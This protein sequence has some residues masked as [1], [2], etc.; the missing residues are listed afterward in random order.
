MAAAS[1]G[2]AHIAELC[3]YIAHALDQGLDADVTAKTQDHILD[4]FAAMVS[5]AR[6]GPGKMAIK[7]ARTLGGARE[8]GVVGTR[9]T[10]TAINAAMAN[11]MM[12]HA[13]E[14]DDSHLASRSHLGCSIVPGALAMAEKC[15]RGGT[16]LLRAVALGY[17]VGARF[18]LALNLGG[19]DDYSLCSHSHG[20][21]FGVA[22]AAAALAGADAGDVQNVL[23]F[24]AQQA[25]G[26]KI[27]MRDQDHLEK[28]FDFGG[29]PARN[30]VTA[31]C[32]VATGFT[33]VPDAICGK[34]GYLANFS[35]D[36]SP[37]RL[38]EGL[39]SRF[40]I[41]DTNIKKWS[42][43][44]PIQAAL[45]SL[46]VLIAEHAITA[47]QVE[48]IAAHMPD[49]RAFIV[50]DRDM[51][52]INLQHLLA[53]MVL[54]GGLSFATSHDEDRMADKAVLEVKRR[55]TLVPEAFLTRA[56]PERQAIIKVTL[57]DGRTLEHRTYDV[58]GTPGNPMGGAEV[59]D[60]A[61]GLMAPIIGDDRAQGLVRAVRG[62]DELDK[63]S[64][65]RAYLG[66]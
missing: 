50:D 45:D 9:M 37:S 54:D 63:V 22:A 55:I 35:K 29:M 23:A 38:S 43:G 57:R 39:G 6:L 18:N 41:M 28:A 51:P 62:L 30:G 33:G 36:P 34:D 64:E 52:D 12:A 3:R 5:G 66:S 53:V 47:G 61:M 1:D 19:I 58:R 21:G 10:T 13:D 8:A 15:G 42:V 32:M 2:E 4:T 11:G 17:D 49:D 14:T 46:E 26:L 24:S 27:Y 25:S 44:S 20:P 48:A 16:A 7:Y 56:R 40:E 31:A 59:D 60:K 65:L